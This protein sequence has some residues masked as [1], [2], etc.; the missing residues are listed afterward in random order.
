M[1]NAIIRTVLSAYPEARFFFKGDNIADLPQTS[2]LL[3]SFNALS[4]AR[5]LEC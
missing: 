3:S 5:L 2:M 1:R 4:S